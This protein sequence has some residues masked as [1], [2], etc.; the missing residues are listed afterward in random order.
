MEATTF[1]PHTAPSEPSHETSSFIS[2][3]IDGK[4]GPGEERH[5][6]E[7]TE[8]A[9]EPRLSSLLDPPAVSVDSPPK[10]ALSPRA[11]FVVSAVWLLS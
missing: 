1:P 9:S 7:M 3:F 5:V 10:E 6:P 2:H 4:E 11:A 8:W